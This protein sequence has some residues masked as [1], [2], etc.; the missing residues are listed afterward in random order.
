VR[1]LSVAGNFDDCQRMVKQAFV[2]PALTARLQLSSANSINVG[3]LLPQMVCTTPAPASSSAP[4]DGHPPNFHHP[5]RQPRQRAR[6]HLGARGGPAD[7]RDRAGEQCQP[8]RARV[9]RDRGEWR[10]RRAWRRSPRPWT[11]A[12]RATWRRLRWLFRNPT[13]CAARS[14]RSRSATRRSAPPSA[15]TTAS[16]ARPGARTPR[17]RPACTA[18]GPGAS[19]ASLGAGGH[20]PPAKFDDVV[21]PLIGR[22]PV[23]VPEALAAL[24]ALPARQ[25]EVGQ[26]L[27]DLRTA[28]EESA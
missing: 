28:L 15:A 24:L 22:P 20:G 18:A 3:R 12:T 27:E 26:R 8:H 21:E 23:P 16:S 5:D 11:S 19:R 2:D 13:A 1:T 14:R 6:L 7:R 17:P 25:V 9:P 4:R 10:P